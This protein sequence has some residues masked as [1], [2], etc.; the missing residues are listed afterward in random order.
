M[1]DINN[2]VNTAIQQEINKAITN[3]VDAY[4]ADVQQE[5]RRQIAALQEEVNQLKQQRADSPATGSDMVLEK[6]IVLRLL[7]DN[8]AVKQAVYDIAYDA[9]HAVLDEHTEAYDHDSYDSAASAI[10]D[11]NLDS[12]PDFDDFVKHDA[13]EDAIR[14]AISIDDY[15]KEEEMHD[16]IE[17]KLSDLVDVDT[18]VTKDD[19]FEAVRE[20]VRDTIE[21]RVS[22]S[23]RLD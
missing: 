5:H 21:N 12:L 8:A 9:G 13:L 23:L 17:E 14:D 10:D 19:M 4:M 22:V 1:I 20:V 2:I 16:A 11:A 7:K 18:L 6:E 3:Y 15:V